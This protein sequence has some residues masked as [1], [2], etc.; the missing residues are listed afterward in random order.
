M[1]VGVGGSHRP[2]CFLCSKVPAH[3]RKAGVQTHPIAKGFK[4]CELFLSGN[5]K[6]TLNIQGPRRQ[7]V[8][9]RAGYYLMNSCLRLTV[10]KHYSSLN[11]VHDHALWIPHILVPY[12]LIEVSVPPL[13]H[14]LKALQIV[15]AILPFSQCRF[16]FLT[17]SALI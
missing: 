5:S 9:N 13:T 2:L 3:R 16:S 12:E 11:Q 6:D 1:L 17:P 15:Q 8:A 7:P 10:L 4:D 14:L